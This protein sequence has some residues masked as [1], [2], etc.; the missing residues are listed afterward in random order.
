MEN[1]IN[2]SFEGAGEVSSLFS[3]AGASTGGKVRIV[4]EADITEL[5]EE[6]AMLVPDSI[7]SVTSTD[8]AGSEAD[9]AKDATGMT[10][11]VPGA[12]VE[13]DAPSMVHVLTKKKSESGG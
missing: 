9:E 8:P 4:I 13:E 10:E 11:D 2:L 7:E 12:D 1:I 6:G 3:D 5:T